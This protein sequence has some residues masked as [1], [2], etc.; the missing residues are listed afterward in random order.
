[1]RL[2]PALM[3]VL[4]SACANPGVPAAA[5]SVAD[6]PALQMTLCPETRPEICTKEYLPVCAS[7]DTGIRCVRAPC[8]SMEWKTYGNACDAC[9]D[10]KVF[11]YIK[12]ACKPGQ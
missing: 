12:G 7:R 3:I 4:C 2:L 11:G 6:K 1:M 9:A 8:P 5:P 10:T